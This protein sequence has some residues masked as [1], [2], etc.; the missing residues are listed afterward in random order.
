MAERDYRAIAERF[1]EAFAVRH[2]AR[3]VAELFSEDATIWEPMMA[4]PLKGRKA[5]EEWYEAMLRA[6]PDV[7]GETTNVFGARDYFAWEWVMRG[8]HTGPL[9]GPQGEVPPTGRR[10]EV[11]GCE[12]CRLD[13]QGLIY[14]ARSYWDSASMMQQLGLMP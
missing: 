1:R 10:A 6:F 13:A 8:T 5:V 9:V 11:R 3:A 4:E 7:S 12:V 14:E 2:D